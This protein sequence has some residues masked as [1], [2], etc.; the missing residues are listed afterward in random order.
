MKTP[1]QSALEEVGAWDHRGD[2]VAE[3]YDEI[4]GPGAWAGAISNAALASR[5]TSSEID[6]NV[7]CGEA[8]H[9]EARCGNASC[10][11]SAK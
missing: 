3:R 5:E 6:I 1:A 11:R 9:D 7:D 10:C 4:H 8:G 2:S